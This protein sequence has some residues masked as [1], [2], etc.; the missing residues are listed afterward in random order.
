MTRLETAALFAA[1][2][3]V[4]IS[5]LMNSSFDAMTM[6][7]FFSCLFAASNA[8]CN[9]STGQ[10]AAGQSGT[11]GSFFLRRGRNLAALTRLSSCAL[12][13]EPG[14]DTRRASASSRHVV[15]AGSCPRRSPPCANNAIAKA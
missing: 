14:Q 6:A 11:K 12:R 3:S 15:Q 9:S 13:L 5:V 2:P 1:T 10:A 7:S 8:S 4:W